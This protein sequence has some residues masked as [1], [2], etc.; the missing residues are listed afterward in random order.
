MDDSSSN[1][2]Y[3]TSQDSSFRTTEVVREREALSASAQSHAPMQSKRRDD[4]DV[5]GFVL[6]YN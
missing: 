2:T 6:G 4:E 3:S 5:N 1:E